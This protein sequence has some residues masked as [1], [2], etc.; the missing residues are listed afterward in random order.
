M[1]SMLEDMQAI[2]TNWTPEQAKQLAHATSR[3]TK[4]SDRLERGF[5][6]NDMALHA[7]CQCPLPIHAET[8]VPPL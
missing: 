5:K 4:A 7:G 6:L 1:K 8:Q 2:A 3:P